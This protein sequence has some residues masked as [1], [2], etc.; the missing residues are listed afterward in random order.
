MK[1]HYIMIS[2]LILFLTAVWPGCKSSRDAKTEEKKS[3]IEK[4]IQEAEK[5]PKELKQKNENN[6]SD[7][8]GGG[9]RN[10]VKSVM[11]MI[12]DADQSGSLSEEE[13]RRHHLEDAMGNSDTDG[14]R[15]VS[16]KEADE[17]FRNFRDEIESLLGAHNASSRT[18]RDRIS[19]T[20]KNMDKNQNGT[21]SSDELKNHWL[22][23]KFEQADTD[24]DSEL[25]LREIIIYCRS[26][27]EIQGP[28]D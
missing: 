18:L 4:A 22:R 5:R 21:L 10:P 6:I 26:N 28:S 27:Q 2:L 24:G 14:N 1:H 20:V 16:R 8:D 12:M 3:T 13:L 9:Q 19:F 15:K 11:F 23:E 25:T 7:Q 17:Y